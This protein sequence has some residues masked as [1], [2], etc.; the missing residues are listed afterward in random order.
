MIN[1]SNSQNQN[2]T[3]KAVDRDYFRQGRKEVEALVPGEAMKILDVGCGEGILGKRLL[4]RR[5]EP[6]PTLKRF[7]F[8]PERSDAIELTCIISMVSSKG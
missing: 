2:G 7:H 4:D 8:E 3:D 5:N 1:D 6:L